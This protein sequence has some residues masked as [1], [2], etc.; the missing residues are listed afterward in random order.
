MR[1]GMPKITENLLQMDWLLAAIWPD[2]W[3]TQ[4]S[5]R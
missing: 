4:Y 5:R 1:N 2:G 3:L